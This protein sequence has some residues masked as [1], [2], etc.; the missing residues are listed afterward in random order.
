MQILFTN[1]SNLCGTGQKTV[2]L[3][4]FVGVVII[5]NN[6][7]EEFYWIYWVWKIYT[8]EHLPLKLIKQRLQNMFLNVNA[9]NF[10]NTQ[11]I[12]HY[13]FYLWTMNIFVHTKHTNSL[14]ESSN[15]LYMTVLGVTDFS[16]FLAFYS[17]FIRSPSVKSCI[18]KDD[19][20]MWKWANSFT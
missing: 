10:V 5:Y 1:M 16:I 20:T 11:Y 14:F 9:Y 13:Q 6:F 15:V 2:F 7:L 18:I 12:P 17:L 8:K 3:T 19:T 4:V